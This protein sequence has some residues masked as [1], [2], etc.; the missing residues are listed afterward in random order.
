MIA[1]EKSD[2]TLS[3]LGLMLCHPDTRKLRNGWY[4]LHGHRYWIGRL[5]LNKLFLEFY[6]TSIQRVLTL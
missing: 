4:L 2:P 5:L 1:D 6:A 3:S